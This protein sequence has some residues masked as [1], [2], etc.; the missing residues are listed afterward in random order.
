MLVFLCLNIAWYSCIWKTSFAITNLY[1][2]IAEGFFFLPWELIREKT[3]TQMEKAKGR[4]YLICSIY[5]LL[6]VTET[7]LGI[8]KFHLI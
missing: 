3:K 7:N 5:R 1:F 8:H 2:S 6:S 4:A